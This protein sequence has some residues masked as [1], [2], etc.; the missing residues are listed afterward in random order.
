MYVCI[1]NSVTDSDIRRA[2]RDGVRDER[3]LARKTGCSSDC[4]CCA[5]FAL[6]VMNQ[7]LREQNA[8]LPMLQTA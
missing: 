3:E 7:A 5:E 4:G 1:C 8:L 2:V 6:E